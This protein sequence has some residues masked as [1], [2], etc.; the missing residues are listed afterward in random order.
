MTIYL[1]SERIKQLCRE[2][3]WS[4][5]KLAKEAGFEQSTLSPI[6]HEKNMPSLYT[7]SD[8]CKAFNITPGS[9]FDCQLFENFASTDNYIKLWKQLNKTEREK[10]LIYMCG[11][12]HKEINE[13][14]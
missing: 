3:G 10:V 14:A 4:Y 5:Y 6:L 13:E 7:L 12:L 2:R 11:L 8:I 1:I 9:F